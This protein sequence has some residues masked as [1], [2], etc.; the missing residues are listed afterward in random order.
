MPQVKFSGLITAMKGKAGGSIFSQNKQGAYFRNNRW[1]GGRKSPRWDAAKQRLQLL[2]NSW[3][4]LSDE[5]RQAWQDAAINFP[6][7]NKF[8][9]P[10]IGSGYQVYMSLNGN[11]LGQNLPLL[12]VPGEN[13]PFPD[14]VQITV[15]TPNNPW[16]TGGTGATFPNLSGLSLEACDLDRE[17]PYGFMCIDNVCTPVSTPGSPEYV[18]ARQL[19]KDQYFQF[20][21]PECTSDADCVDAG[22]AGASADVACTDG[23]CVYVGDG[24]PVYEQTAYVLN[25]GD[26]LR[27]DG[28][29][30]YKNATHDSRLTGSFRFTLGTAALRQLNTTQ[31]EIVLISNYYQDG[32]GT[33]IRIRPQDQQTTR[34]YITFGLETPTSVRGTSTYV[35]YAD[36]NTTELQTNSVLQFTI[37][38]GDTV[39][40]FIC[41]NGSGFV[42]GQF[43]Y[44][45]GLP[46][47]PISGWG[48]PSGDLHNP[49]AEW[50]TIHHWYGIVY[51]GGVLQ[52]SSDIIYSDMRFYSDRVTEFKY[53]LSG[54]V[55][56][57]ETI[58][59]TANGE[60][61]PKCSYKS[62]TLN[63]D[64]CGDNRNRCNCAAGICGP[65]RQISE[66]F[67]NKAANGNPNIRLVAAVPVYHLMYAAAAKELAGPA[68]LPGGPILTFSDY[69]LNQMGGQFDNNGATFV[70]LT[71]ASI[72][73]T[74]QS[75][76][77]IIV[78]ITRARGNGTTVRN[79]EFIDMA[80]L[81]ADISTDWE[82]WEFIKPAITTA[83]PG[84]IFWI[85][86]ELIDT[87][88]GLSQRSAWR[89]P[90]FKAGAELSSSVN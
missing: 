50:L 78:S 86:F 33:T 52:S 57:S 18:A 30:N 62:C 83:P 38:P 48:E 75:G 34:V 65:W 49:Y 27:N 23:K 12:T 53:A 74:L 51:G 54:M 79:T 28:N 43:V 19:A 41:L 1:G 61:K 35:W 16:V 56:G 80:Y 37:H 42:Y 21:D 73:G 46:S 68:P 44:Y 20:A 89:R 31:N 85:A 69:W 15:A 67:S 40:S 39:N 25:V 88:S 84:S 47:G 5:Q 71:T 24:V 3:R 17:C 8:K 6:F 2:S 59:I 76:F 10:Y 70:P 36:F 26:T 22:L 60:S 29:W 14:D 81:P 64:F 63:D 87:N 7:E 32:R 13:R 66:S 55:E 90:R 82:L 11:L 77:G 4:L 9:E 45:E 72:V 58:I